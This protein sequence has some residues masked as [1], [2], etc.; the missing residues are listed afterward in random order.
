MVRTLHAWLDEAKDA[1]AVVCISHDLAFS[2]AI[3][4]RRLHM[5]G[6]TLGAGE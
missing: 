4:T 3:A 5:R 1:R 2:D 6:G